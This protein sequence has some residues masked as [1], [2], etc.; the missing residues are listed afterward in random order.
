MLDTLVHNPRSTV[1]VIFGDRDDFTGIQS[2]I[3]WADGLQAISKDNEAGRLELVTVKGCNHFWTDS[4]ARQVLV[5]SI[6][7]FVR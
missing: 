3:K 2:Y 1:L 4:H 7:H 6:Q 5:D